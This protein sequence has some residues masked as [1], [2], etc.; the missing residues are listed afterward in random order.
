MVCF[1]M[2][3]QVEEVQQVA[4]HCNGKRDA[5]KKAQEQADR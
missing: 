3:W 5:S 2:G 4:Q 1:S